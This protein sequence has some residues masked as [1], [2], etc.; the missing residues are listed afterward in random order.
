M[1]RVCLSL[2]GVDNMKNFV[3]TIMA[4]WNRG[5]VR[6]LLLVLLFVIAVSLWFGTKPL[7]DE[8]KF[9]PIAYPAI[10]EGTQKLSAPIPI[11]FDPSLEKL[12][13]PKGLSV[14]SL[15]KSGEGELLDVFKKTVSELNLP[16][17]GSISAGPNYKIWVS[18]DKK[19]YFEGNLLTG[20]FS[21]GG[22]SIT[23]IS[24][25]NID[26]LT[27]TA[28]QFFKNIGLDLDG[29]LSVISYLNQSGME[30][31]QAQ[32]KTTADLI[33]ITFI[34]TINGYKIK[35]VGLNSP[36]I[37]ILLGAKDKKIR[38]VNYFG[39]SVNRNINGKYNTLSLNDLQKNIHTL[40]SI[41]DLYGASGGVES[42]EEIKNIVTINITKIEIEY[43][44]AYEEQ[45]LLK[46]VFRLWG[47]VKYNNN[48]TG[49]IE[50][51]APA[52]QS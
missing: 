29:Y 2:E 49:E 23:T 45:S 27:V 5:I 16:P 8:G 33:Q 15:K 14:Y 11:I 4:L 44:S 51:I 6:M 25:N 20:F 50:A 37:G 47:N 21:F 41:T 28:K 7:K 34:Q 13:F 26:E 52:I 35:G 40:L 39:L 12:N 48:S 32:D 46:P 10:I 1:T 43:L 30:Y 19:G 38:E 31:E 17:E 18:G 9:G 24:F 42:M 3:D 22:E 36:N